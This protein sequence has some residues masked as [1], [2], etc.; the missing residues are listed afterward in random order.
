MALPRLQTLR[1]LR[2]L[3]G[4][5][6]LPRKVTQRAHTR[7]FVLLKLRIS[8]RFL[9]SDAKVLENVVEDFVGGDFADD[10][11]EAVEGVADV[12]G[13]EVGGLVFG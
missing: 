7:T 13:H 11:A 10:G 1:P 2:R 9:F 4:I 12:L 5:C 3:Q 8:F 6:P